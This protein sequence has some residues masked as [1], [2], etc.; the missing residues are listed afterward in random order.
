MDATYAR[1]W[2]DCLEAVAKILAQSDDIEILKKKVAKLKKLIQEDKFEKIRYE[3]GA[4]DL[5]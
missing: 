3:L 1:G 4:F 2:D 5:F